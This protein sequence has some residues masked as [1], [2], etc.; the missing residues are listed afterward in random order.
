VPNSP[1]VDA[2]LKIVESRQDIDGRFIGARRV[3]QAGGNGVFSLVFRARDQGTGRD[4]AIKVFNPDCKEPYRIACF[5]REAKILEELRD[6]PDIIG[7]VAPRSTFTELTT[8]TAGIAWPITFEYYALELAHSDVGSV[9]ENGGWNVEQTLRAFHVMCR[10]VQRIHLRRIAHRDL[11]PSN[12]LLMLDGSVKL[13]DF[14]TARNLSGPPSAILPRYDAPPGDTR[15]AS[16]ELIAGLHD[17]DPE[18]GF[19]GDIFA[20]GSILYELVTGTCLGLVL[21]YRFRADL[22]QAMHSVAQGQR[23]RVYDQIVGQI[24]DSYPLPGL[25]ASGTQ[26]PA[27]IMDRIEELYKSMAAMSYTAR[28]S[29]F[30]RIFRAIRTCQIILH[31][32][33]Q[34][35]RWRKNGERYRHDREEKRRRAVP[36]AQ[37]GLKGTQQ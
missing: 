15:Y 30:S 10:A 14:G 27:G 29:D 31:N 16:P 18:F 11:K 33:E 26:I 25:A 19:H 36:R 28:L 21:D 17:E 20:L 2:Y 9:I 23:R 35:Q 32:E 4:V 1:T 13:S 34:Y 37:C 12:F 6:Q 8:T 22:A 3:G 24:A 7:W 5:R